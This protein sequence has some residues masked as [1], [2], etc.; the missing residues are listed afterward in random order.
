MKDEFASVEQYFKSRATV[1]KA[2]SGEETFRRAKEA[3]SEW[4]AALSSSKIATLFAAIDEPSSIATGTSKFNDRD[5]MAKSLE[6]GVPSQMHSA[7][8]SARKVAPRKLV[9]AEDMDE[10]DTK[11]T[12]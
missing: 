7:S 8:T 11:A 12:A 2:I 1:D 10:K 4:L 6:R 5:Y 9:F 3:T